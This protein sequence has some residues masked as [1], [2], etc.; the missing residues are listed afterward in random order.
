MDNKKIPRFLLGRSGQSTVEYIMLLVVIMSLGLLVF[1]SA[2]F[3]NVL[4]PNSSMFA[5]MA[6]KMEFSYRYG[7]NGTDDTFRD[8]GNDY[9]TPEHD[10]YRNKDDGRSRFFAPT[11]KYE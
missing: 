8:S 9:K 5:A 7:H 3:K 6:K 4:G 2:A 10:A 11:S 1:K